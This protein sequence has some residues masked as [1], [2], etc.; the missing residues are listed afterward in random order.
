MFP[1]I[2]AGLQK[3]VANRLAVRVEGQVVTCLYLPVGVRAAA[4]VS[5]PIGRAA[6]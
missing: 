2:G 4:G 1:L 6:F 3:K 5:I